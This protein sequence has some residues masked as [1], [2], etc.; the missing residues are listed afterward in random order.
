[1]N[2]YARGKCPER[3][4]RE[5]RKREE[6]GRGGPGLTTS[7]RRVSLRNPGDPLTF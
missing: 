5:K 7:A 2:L 3:E 4:E 6:G 1:M